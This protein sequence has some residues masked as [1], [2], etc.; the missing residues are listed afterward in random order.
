MGDVQVD[1]VAREHVGV[2]AA[3]T[4]FAHQEVDHLS[5]RDLDGGLEVFVKS[6]RHEV[7]RGFG[8]RPAQPLAFVDQETKGAGECGFK[9]SDIDFAVT[10]RGMGVTDQK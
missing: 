7:G 5:Q 3:K 1:G 10:L 4:L 9:R 2:V 6:H 8:A